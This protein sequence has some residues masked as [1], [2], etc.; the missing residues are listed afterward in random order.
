MD[1][2]LDWDELT[3]LLGPAAASPDLVG[4]SISCYNPEKDPGGGD[5]RAIVA[6]DGPAPARLTAGRACPAIVRAWMRPS[7]T[8]THLTP[9]RAEWLGRIDYR[10]AHVLQRRLAAERADGRIG[11]RLLLLEHPRGP[12]ARS[13]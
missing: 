7:S 3:E 13:Q 4:W 12:D 11:D 2:G 8:P 1:G 5:G 10:D 6:G 9:I